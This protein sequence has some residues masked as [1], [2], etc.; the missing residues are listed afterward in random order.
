[1]R[2]TQ[3]VGK[4]VRTAAGTAWAG[5]MTIAGLVVLSSQRGFL[6]R[7]TTVRW[8]VGIALAAGGLFVFMVLVADRWFRRASKPM[9]WSAE[10]VCF[11]AFA[12]APLVTVLVALFQ[13]GG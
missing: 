12:G 9:I 2:L 3:K 11:A 10:V 13:T 8:S 1:M 6:G 7:V 4:T 5:A